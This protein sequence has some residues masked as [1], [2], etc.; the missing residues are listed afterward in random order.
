MTTLGHGSELDWTAARAAAERIIAR[1]DDAAFT[2]P[3]ETTVLQ[4]RIQL[5][6]EELDKI[7]AALRIRV[8]VKP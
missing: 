7:V 8:P 4:A 5:V 3:E 1:C 2:A 6:C